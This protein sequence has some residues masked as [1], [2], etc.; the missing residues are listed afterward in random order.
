MR[1]DKG[2]GLN[3]GNLKSLTAADILASDHVVPANH[4]ALG[5]GEAGAVS[6]IGSAGQLI[7]FSPH[8]P[9]E[10]VLALLSA[11]RA[12]HGVGPLF[13]TLI[14]KVPFFHPAPLGLRP[15]FFRGPHP[16]CDPAVT[17]P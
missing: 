10:L 14:E 13:R 3:A 5:L 1:L 7:L 4:V 9:P 17:G 12:G 6:V 15:V 16:F 8:D 2:D 11:V